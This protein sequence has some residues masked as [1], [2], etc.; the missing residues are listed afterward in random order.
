M[1]FS[2]PLQEVQKGGSEMTGFA[3]FVKKESLHILRDKWTLLI[4]LILPIVQLLLF[5]FAISIEINN[6]NFSVSAPHRTEAVRK[7]T[8]Q[9]SSNPYFTFKGYIARRNQQFPECVR[10]KEHTIITDL[11]RLSGKYARRQSSA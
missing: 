8:E 7:Q 10:Q 3:S 4:I 6:I 5:G 2:V 9:I 11:A 1:K